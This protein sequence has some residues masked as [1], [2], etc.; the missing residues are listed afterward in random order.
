MRLGDVAPRL[1]LA[2]DQWVAEQ[3]RFARRERQRAARRLHLEW[4][5]AHRELQLLRAGARCRSRSQREYVAQRQR[6]L[7]AARRELADLEAAA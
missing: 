6:K 2:R 7:D 1:A 4:L 5:V 3:E